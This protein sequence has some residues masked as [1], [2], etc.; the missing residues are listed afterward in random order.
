MIILNYLLAISLVILSV[1][2]TADIFIQSD[3]ALGKIEAQ[4]VDQ[5][6]GLLKSPDNDEKGNISLTAAVLTTILSLLLLFFIAK[7]KIEYREAIYRKDSYL[8]FHYLN[9]QTEKYI[10]EM[11]IF[12][13]ALTA[14]FAAQGSGV[15]TAEAIEV[16]KALT[17]ARNIRHFYY[18]KKLAINK[19]CQLPET[20]SYLKNTPFKIQANLALI[21]NPDETSII[22]QKKWSYLYYKWPTGIRL[23]KSFCLKSEFQME[24][25]FIPNT[26]YTSSEI[27]IA[28][29][30]SL[31]CFSGPSS[32]PSS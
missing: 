27:Q 25:A 15:A 2:K 7:M 11:A 30:S 8:C 13:W 17:I 12:N 32:S 6:R 16:F 23:K 14:A 5:T 9:R 31:K 1:V 19:Y 24:D 20:Y 28:G 21:T 3:K 10:T 4:F 22:R 29:L 18:L 26:T